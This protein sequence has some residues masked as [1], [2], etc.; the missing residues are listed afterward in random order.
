MD[1]HAGK[2]LA[3]AILAGV[4]M[5]ATAVAGIGLAT[6]TEE[7][8]NP[9]LCHETIRVDGDASYQRKCVRERCPR[10]DSGKILKGCPIRSDVRSPQRGRLAAPS[11]DQ[12]PDAT[13][14]TVVS[15]LPNP[16][17]LPGTEVPQS[18]DAPNSD[19]QG[20][21]RSDVC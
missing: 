6:T 9:R 18:C 17:D 1:T 10:Q 15:E 7:A 19:P 4:I 12:H 14:F 20:V 16:D 5:T 3:A 8:R 2:K 21:I 13:L 11:T